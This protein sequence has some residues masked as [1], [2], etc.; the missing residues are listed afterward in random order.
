MSTPIFQPV[1]SLMFV[2]EEDDLADQ[3]AAAMPQL[4]LLRVK[5]AAGA[6]ERMVV[7]RP[8]VVVVD[9]AVSEANVALVVECAKDIRAEVIRASVALRATLGEE[10]RSA[11]LLAESKRASDALPRA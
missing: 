4:Q 9:E 6:V 3:C 1:P 10:V 11:A 8:L 5:H 7:T 2:G